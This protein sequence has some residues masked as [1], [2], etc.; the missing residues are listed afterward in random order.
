MFYAIA[1]DALSV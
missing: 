1:T